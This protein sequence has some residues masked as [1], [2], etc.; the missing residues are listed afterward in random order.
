VRRLLALLVLVGLAVASCSLPD[1]DAPDAGGDDAFGDAGD[2]EIVDAAVSSEKIEL[3]RTLALAFNDSDEAELDDD[4]CVF[5]RPY[6]KSSGGATRI[7]ADG[8]DDEEADGPR[9][10][11][12]SPASSAWAAILNQRLDDQ[13]LPPMAPPSEPFMLTPLV[14]AM[15]R[16]MADALGY[17]DEPIGFADIL[18]LSQDPEGWGAYGH[19]EWGPFRLGKTNP[20]FSTSGLSA[21]LAQYYAATGKSEGLSLEDLARPDVVEFSRAIESSV[22][23]YGDITMTF[24]NNLFR[25]DARGASLTY[26]S[27]V[28]IEEKSVIDYNAGNPDGVLD[29]GEEA[30][31]PREP[32]VAVYPE[33]GTLFSD[34]PFIV[35]DADWVTDTQREGARRFEAFV[36]RP[37]NQERVLEY[38]FRPGN[39][40][41]PVGSP[42]V[43]GNGVNPDEPTRT[44]EVPAPE[45]M[46]EVLDRWAEQRKAAKVMLLIDVSGSMGDVAN[47][48]T[49]ETKLDLAKRAAIEALDQFKADDEVALRIFSTSL[50]ATEPS[51]YIDVVPFGPISANRETIATRIRQ[52]VPTEGTPL[53]TAARDAY[54]VMQEEYDAARINAIVL[55][56]DGVNEDPR[57]TDLQGL[58]DELGAS[59]E[60]QSSRPVRLFPIAYGSGADINVLQQMAEATNAAA[61][62]ASDPRSI[63]NVFTAVVSNF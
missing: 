52:L 8:W 26:A 40:S 32:L 18:R 42:I 62:D 35:L 39:P 61:Y 55:L 58:L 54:R 45:V 50:S 2:C 17:P 33:E 15:P 31:P 34:N 60:G 6:S 21:L 57:N 24:L 11:I 27:A 37:E 23:H 53:Y 14:I 30:R 9:P 63:T 46:I 48:E 25:N 44:L 38:G 43:A 41:V 12:W 1:D 3:L 36:Q 10:E 7:L 56:S 49:G 47:D 59:N 22:V 5:V 19:P 13:G 4:A 20:N 16:Q 51:D 29:P 28:A